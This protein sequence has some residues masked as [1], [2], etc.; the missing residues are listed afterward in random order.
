MSLSTAQPL[1]TVA[2]AIEAAHEVADFCAEHA[3]A[4]D[5]DEAFPAL[6]M[7]RIA[8]SGLLAVPFARAHGG[9]GLGSEPG[10][11]ADLLRILALL[12]AGN[13]S[14]ARLFEGH[15]NAVL[16]IQEF[17]S[18]SQIVDAAADR[19]LFAVWNTQ[20]RDG[21]RLTPLDER[22]YRLDGAKT[23]AS[24]AGSIE[25]PL[26]TA[27][28]PDGGWQMAA[29][30]LRERDVAVDLS[31]W[32]SAGMRATASGRVDFS[33]L[34]IP[35]EALI[36]APGDYYRQPWFSAGSL[37]FAA[38]HLGGAISLVEA[39]R[40]DLRAHERTEDDAQRMRMG[41]I[42]IAIESGLLLME[43]AA[44]LADRSRFG[45]AVDPEIDDG[46]MVAYANLVRSAIERICLDAIEYAQRSVGV[47][48]MLKP[49]PI[50]RISRDLALYL[51]QPAPDDA[52][53]NVG[54]FSLAQPGGLHDSWGR[55]R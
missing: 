40:G 26:I 1:Q 30:D 7:A 39:A 31:G 17:G 24:G 27:A 45:G 12:G 25:R 32:R 14:V 47:R 33:G 23:F 20:G 42:A 43:R 21:V 49:H 52:L 48:S 8:E 36:G 13:L 19:R 16:L 22:R 18:P 10:G 28:L 46:E 35:S 41:A 51:R 6:E 5:V 55:S 4:I 44:A 3:P 54:T 11:M 53:R 50:E 37:R 9:L 29:L 15:V 34:T 2:G 38:A